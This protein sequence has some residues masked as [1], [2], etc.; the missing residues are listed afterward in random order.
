LPQDLK[1]LR[2]LPGVGRYTAGAIASIAFNMDEPT[3]DGNIR[4]VLARLFD[5]AEPVR[6]GPGERRLWELAAA[7]LP[8]GQ[9][10]AFNQALMDL[11]ATLCTPRAPSCPRCPLKDLCLAHL[12]GT[13]EQRPVVLSR[14]AIPHYIV[15]AAVIE[16]QG[17]FLLAQRPPDG[18]LGSLWEFPGGKLRPGEELA[19]CLKR[20]ISEELAAEIIIG[21]PIGVYRHA[22]THFRITLHA[23]CCRLVNASQPQAQQVQDLRWASL[24]ELP[25]FPMGKIDRQIASRLME[26][27]SC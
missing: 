26:Q 14:P 6:S 17:C 11:G 10:G 24:N 20:E 7:I 12:S 15:T 8:P 21:S 27:G 2:R 4:R 23:F 22:Y 16:R 1:D 3:L 25:N 9:A 18:L 19:D 5:V 13:Q